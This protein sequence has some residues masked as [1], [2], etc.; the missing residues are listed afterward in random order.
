MQ[1][2]GPEVEPYV[3]PSWRLLQATLDTLPRPVLTDEDVIEKIEL[4]E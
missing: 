4:G 2:L 1:E 3:A